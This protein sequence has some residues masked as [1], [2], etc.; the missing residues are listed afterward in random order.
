MLR[1]MASKRILWSLAAA[2]LLVALVFLAFGGALG[3]GFVRFDDHGYVYENPMVL[4]GLTK[5]GIRWAFTSAYQQWW[6]P[7]LWISYMATVD[8]FGPGAF[9]FHLVNLL[10][11]AANAGLLFWVLF[12]LTGSRWRSL[13]VAALFAVHPLRVESVVWITERKDVLSGLFFF[14]ALLAYL[15]PAE[16]PGAR[17][18]GR[19]FAC[20]LLGLMSKATVIVLPALLLLLDFWPLRRAEVPWDPGAWKTWGRLVAEKIPLFLLA[21]MFAAINLHTHTNGFGAGMGLSWLHRLA[22][23]PGNTWT[24]LRLVFWPVN[25]CVYYPEN[26]AVQALPALAALAGLGALTGLAAWQG[27]KRSYLLVGW[28]W[29]LVALLPVLRGIRLGNAAYADRFTYLPSIGLALVVVWGVAELL[30]WIGCRPGPLTGRNSPGGGTR[31][32]AKHIAILAMPVALML[33]LALVSRRQAKVWQDSETLFRHALAVTENNAAI[34]YNLAHLLV[35]EGR[36]AEAAEAYREILRIAPGNPVVQHNLAW[37]LA[38]DPAVT[39]EQAQEALAL[40]RRVIEETGPPNAMV[41]NTLERAQAAGEDYLGAAQTAREAMVLAEQAGNSEL[42]S[43]IQWRIRF[44]ATK[45]ANR[46]PAQQNTNG[47]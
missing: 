11:H 37:A 40:V 36:N 4:A 35:Q 23:L 22:L 43:K 45:T 2:L 41:L 29:F 21:G 31:P 5:A 46:P 24:Y 14:L 12:R 20:M 33:G 25:L 15:R 10:L 34:H 42:I 18:L 28:L 47:E 30:E 8:L 19:V 38:T 17:S 26:D 27:K 16:R 9:G 3:F 39:P 32:T 13:A 6:L 1:G 7:A 44:Y